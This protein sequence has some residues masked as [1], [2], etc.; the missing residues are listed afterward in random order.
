VGTPS[1]NGTA[2]LAAVA[3]ITTASPTNPFL[4]RIE[5]GIYDLGNQSLT[6]P[7]SV[8]IEGSGAGVTTITASAAPTVTVPAGSE[9]RYVTVESTFGLAIN[10]S[11]R[12]LYVTAKA[13]GGS[14]NT[15]IHGSNAASITSSTAIVFG[16]GVVNRAISINGDTILFNFTADSTG[17]TST[18]RAVDYIGNPGSPRFVN[19]Y[20]HVAGSQGSGQTMQAISLQGTSSATLDSVNAIAENGGQFGGT[21]ALF[22]AQGTHSISNS[23]LSA[24][25]PFV[26]FAIQADSQAVILAE[27]SRLATDGNFYAVSAADSGTII[28][29]G[30][31]RMEGTPFLFSGGTVMCAAVYNASFTFFANACP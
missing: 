25:G 12:L 28:R 29:V 22:V 1:D 2:L 3:G 16:A 17:A 23:S 6:P 4:V 27:N 14:S 9:L 18:G 11:G 20:A 30:A 13:S 26:R 5:P 8:D 24:K 21:V 10:L 31:S 19:V 15:A 7:S